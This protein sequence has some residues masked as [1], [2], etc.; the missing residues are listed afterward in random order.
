GV[1]GSAAPAAFPHIQ[2]VELRQIRITDNRLAGRWAVRRGSEVRLVHRVVVPTPSAS[3]AAAAEYGIYLRNLGRVAVQIGQ[4]NAVV[5]LVDRV[6][7]L[8]AFEEAGV[9]RPPGTVAV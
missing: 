7:V 5:R 6:G 2:A 1:E 3:R 8:V 9:S 4:P